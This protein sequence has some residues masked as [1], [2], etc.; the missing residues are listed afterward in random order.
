MLEPTILLVSQ[1]PSVIDAVKGASESLPQ[2]KIEICP[3]SAQ[4]WKR[5]LREDVA[6]VVAHLTP[7]GAWGIA[8]LLRT[9]TECDRF[10][11]ILVLADAPSAQKHLAGHWLGAG[12]T[13]YLEVPLELPKLK[14]LLE[15]L[16]RRVRWSPPPPIRADLELAGLEGL[17]QQVCRVASQD[18]TLLLEGETGTGKTRLARVVHELSPRRDEPFLVIDCGSLSANLIESELFGHAKGSFTGADRQRTGK[19]AAA[20]AGTLLLDEIN[21]LPMPLQTKLLRATD[22]RVYEPLGSDRSLPFRARLIAATNSPLEQEVAAGRF[23]SDLYYRLNVISLFLPGLRDRRSSIAP[24]AHR[25]LMEL[26]AR[27]RP[28]VTGFSPAVLTALAEYH[29]PGNIR[30]LR[31]MVERMV[32]LCEG[33]LIEVRD[34]PQALRFLG[35]NPQWGL[36]PETAPAAPAPNASPTLME[37]KEEFEIRRIRE[38]LHRNRNN[39][40]LAAT[41]LGLSRNGFYKKLHRY[42]LMNHRFPGLPDTISQYGNVG[43][44]DTN[45]SSRH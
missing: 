15:T 21:S 43:S 18:T 2:L 26:A 27:N 3:E 19:L 10:C 28:D 8:R 30:E 20:G 36:M 6:L 31:N 23:R 45:A 17:V 22:E 9:V 39:R 1:C 14:F 4:A 16:V 38:A 24:L 12:A 33:P 25:F 34:L 7:D 32:A 35:K 13:D 44:V 5:V 37:S 41:E 40:K 11:A 29:W 42:G